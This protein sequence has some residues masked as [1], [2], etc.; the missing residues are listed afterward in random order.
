MVLE[1]ASGETH[2]VS[3][4][5]DRSAKVTHATVLVTGYLI[6]R[7]GEELLTQ[8]LA[9]GLNLI[10]YGLFDTR[11]HMLGQ[12]N[13]IGWPESF[14]FGFANL[15]HSFFVQKTAHCPLQKR[16]GKMLGSHWARPRH[17]NDPLKNVSG[18]LTLFWIGRS[19][20]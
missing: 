17:L 13:V 1:E 3:G 6:E 14:C 19:F 7:R 20:W 18:I 9:G 15:L 12:Q 8:T 4:L 5:N 11:L 10:V 2:L 16:G